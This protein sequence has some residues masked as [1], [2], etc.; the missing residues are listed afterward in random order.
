MVS[1]NLCRNNQKK[2]QLEQQYQTKAW[3]L[4]RVHMVKCT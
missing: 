2:Y 1:V 3:K 4:I